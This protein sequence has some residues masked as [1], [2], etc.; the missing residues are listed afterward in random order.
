MNAFDLFCMRFSLATLASLA[1]GLGIWALAAVCRRHLPAL[2]L[3]R[4]VWLLAQLTIAATFVTVLLP[5]TAQLRVVPAI[6]ID[7]RLPTPVTVAETPTASASAAGSPVQAAATPPNWPLAAARLWLL[8]YCTG[9]LAC[10]WRL[11]RSHHDVERLAKTG[12]ALSASDP[13]AGFDASRDSM[14]VVIEIDAPIS[15]MLF[16]LF[17]PRLLLPR[18]LRSFDALQQQL[19]IA[20]ELRHLRRRDLQWMGAALALQTVFWFHP[21]MRLLRAHLSWAQE[22]ACDRDVLRGRSQRERKAYAAALLAQFKTQYRPGTAGLSTALSFGGASIN[23][24]ASRIGLIRAPGAGGKGVLP[25]ALAL[26]A[27]GAV[28]AGNLALQPALAWHAPAPLASPG[29]ARLPADGA[30]DCTL[31]VDAASG[32]ALQNQGDC[33]SRITPASTFNIVVSLMGFDSGILK[34]AHTPRLPYRADAGYADW[35]SSWRRD[36]DPTSWIKN[37][38][39]WYAQHV[40]Q[41]LG[42][43]GLARYLDSF[44]YGNRDA[45]GDPGKHNGLKMSWISSSMQISPVEQVAF[46]RKL[47]NRQLPIKPYAY[48]MTEQ[49]LN[50]PAQGGWRVYGKTGTSSPVLADGSL[51]L[52]RQYGWFV[53][54]ASK[55]GRKVVFARL[56]LGP[57]AGDSGAGPRLRREFLQGLPARMAAINPI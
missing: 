46:L 7:E 12:V 1:A 17:R 20:H 19:I 10:S 51:D 23:T 35:N 2:S 50:L 21:A 55:G 5:Q 11:L 6:E 34:D 9:L 33:A 44:D 14:P 57:T 8:I 15:P 25:R 26:L 56:L 28:F 45:S 41:Q 18:H 39:V 30:L 37:S 47:V 27:L 4:S 32:A 43:A 49:L 54:W 13:H 53:G 48:D 22:L 52:S 16:G 31:L 24:L 29:S 3:Q 42:E 40:T 38:N 36:T